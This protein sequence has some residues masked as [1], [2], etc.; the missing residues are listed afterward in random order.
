MEKERG[1]IDVQLRL[2][3]KL[4]AFSLLNFLPNVSQS[5]TSYLDKYFSINF[6]CLKQNSD[7]KLTSESKYFATAQFSRKKQ[8]VIKEKKSGITHFYK[9]HVIDS[10]DGRENPPR[11]GP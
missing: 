10:I 11:A 1:L 8:I 9:S 4:L 2:I 5:A 3:S 7:S 6:I